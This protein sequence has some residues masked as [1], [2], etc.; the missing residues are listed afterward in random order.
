MPGARWAGLGLGHL[1][2]RHL[3]DAGGHC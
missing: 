3:P 2:H 1:V